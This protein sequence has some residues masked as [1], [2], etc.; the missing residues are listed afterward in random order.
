MKVLH[1]GICKDVVLVT[2]I[3]EEVSQSSI[4]NELRELLIESGFVH[5]SIV[6]PFAWPD[7]RPTRNVEV[8]VRGLPKD[9]LGVP[10][11]GTPP[12]EIHFP[13]NKF[14]KIFGPQNDIN[15]TSQN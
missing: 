11:R 3:C 12:E 4:C 1:K 6:W 8:T 14:L 7:L 2:L 5:E 10:L 15:K 13:M 9:S